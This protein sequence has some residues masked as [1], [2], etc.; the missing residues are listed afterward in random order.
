MSRLLRP[1]L[2]LALLAALA[3]AAAFQR[4]VAQ[5]QPAYSGVAEAHISPHAMRH[6]LERHGPE[7]TA[8]GAGKFAP[9]TT[10]DLIR[11]MIAEAVRHGRPHANTNG[12]PGTLYDYSFPYDIGTTIDGRPTRRIRVVVGP[13]GEVVT[14]FPR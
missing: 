10:P 7:S 3:L 5:P 8:P 2:I 6:I 9:G 11:A 12:R 4:G 13:D 1:A 14:A